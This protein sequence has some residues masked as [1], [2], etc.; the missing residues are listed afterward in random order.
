MTGNPGKTYVQNYRL[1][2][3]KNI[4]TKKQEKKTCKPNNH[5]LNRD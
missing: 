2:F 1:N 3:I 4:L 5:A